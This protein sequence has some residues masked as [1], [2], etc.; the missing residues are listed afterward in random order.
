M[1]T[2]NRR[3]AR[4]EYA[5][6]YETYVGRVPEGDV[7]AMLRTQLDATVALLEGM[8]AERHDHRY[9][10][11][12]WS[13]KELVGH[14]VD[15]ERVFSFRALA[16]ARGDAQPLPSMDQHAYMQEA[17]FAARSMNSLVAELRHLRLANLELFASFDEAALARRGVASGAE[18]S[19]R[20]L[21][22]IV[23]GH[24]GHHLE[25]LAERYL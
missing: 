16:F 12:K 7:L 10:P 1:T 5:P 11:D 17:G 9:A 24:L 8:P 21:I 14:M 15:A 3:P 20:A 22:Y 4:E 23:A 13:V 25:V 18:V 6:F 19:V 2:L